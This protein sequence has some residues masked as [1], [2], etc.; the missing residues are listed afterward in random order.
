MDNDESK[1]I[2]LSADNLQ[3]IEKRLKEIKERTTEFVEKNPLTSIA[4]AVGVGYLLARIFS[5]KK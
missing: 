4:I 5:G 3:D 1:K 2:G